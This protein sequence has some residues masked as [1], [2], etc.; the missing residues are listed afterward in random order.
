MTLTKAPIASPMGII[1]MGRSGKAAARLLASRGVAVLAFEEKPS[2]ELKGIGALPMQVT[3]LPPNVPPEA[4]TGCQ[5]VLLSPGVP[6]SHALVQELLAAGVPVYNDIELLHRISRIETPSCRFIGI[7][8]SNGKSTV[9]T[10]VGLMLAQSGLNAPTGGNLGEPAC[11]LATPEAQA[12]V[13]ELSSF[14]LESTHL[15]RAEVA[16]LLNISPD[17]MDR[18]PDCDSYAKAKM[19]LFDNQQEGDCAVINADDTPSRPWLPA[20]F[21]AR[22]VRVVPFSI[23][24]LPPGGIGFLEDGLWDGRGATPRC[25]METR[26]LL[27]AGRFNR[28]NAAAAAAVALQAGASEEAVVA[29]LTTFRG[30]PH[31]M[32]T[33]RELDGVLYI[34]DSKGTNVGAVLESLQALPRPLIWI[35]GGR[36]KHSDF[37]PLIEPA[38]RHARCAILLGEAAAD[39]QTVLDGALPLH[40]VG[41]LS[42]AI[43]LARR[44]AQPGDAVLL[45]PACASFDM[46]ANFEDR[47]ARFREAVNAL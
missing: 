26:Q 2:P 1:G 46:F 34:N 31:R 32:E 25:L 41:S 15:F 30:L 16:C 29:V 43:T 45:S 44:L 38:R 37:T 42:E 8:G 12:Y 3:L 13:L 33:V 36:D 20:D 18:Y 17:H 23:R 7:T 19:R 27:I 10:L 5:Q 35:A 40:R 9:T 21:A 11:A 39:M 47:G 22:G 14:Q 4:M 24:E 6:R 28:A